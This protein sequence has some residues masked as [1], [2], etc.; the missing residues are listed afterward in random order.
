M[1]STQTL[2]IIMIISSVIVTMFAIYGQHWVYLPIFI[3]GFLITGIRITIGEFVSIY[4]KNY[5]IVKRKND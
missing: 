3:G 5:Q 4:D 2:G 1:F